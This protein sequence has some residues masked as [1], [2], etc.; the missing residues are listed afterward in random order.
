MKP[1]SALNPIAG[2][3]FAICLLAMASGA[4]AGATRLGDIPLMEEIAAGLRAVAAMD[5]DEKIRNPDT[6]AKEFLTPAF[7]F[8]TSLDEDFEKSKQFIKFYR[9]NAYYTQNAI[10]KHIDGILEAGAGDNIA[11]VVIIGAGLDSRAYRFAD[12]MP[13]VRFFEADLPAAVSRKRELVQAAMGRLQ[14]TVAYV[15]VDYRKETMGAALKRAG[16]DPT[17]KTL[18]ICEMVTRYI[19]AAAVDRVFDEIQKN[20]PAGSQLVF[21]YIFAD[22]ARG[23]FSKMP[24]ARFMSVRV[25]S[26]GYPWKFGIVPDQADQF[27]TSRGFGVLSDLDAGQ[28]AR[29]YLVRSDGTLDGRPVP[30]VR[31]MHAVVK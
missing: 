19:D 26:C 21:D 11:Q 13:G 2:I 4:P 20:A 30:F 1:L 8:W 25:A 22:L 3:V 29:R 9:M 31:I 24:G 17:A 18:F 27:V 12:R 15:P 28:L 7:W 14:Q 23:D 5:P 10:T 6:M 16:Y